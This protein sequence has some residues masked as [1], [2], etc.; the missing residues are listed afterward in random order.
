MRHRATPTSTRLALA[1]L[2]ATGCGGTGDATGPIGGSSTIIVFTTDRHG[3][4]SPDGPGNP[5]IYRMSGNGNDLQRLTDNPAQDWHPA[6]SPDAARIAYIRDQSGARSIRIM[7]SDGTDDRQVTGPGVSAS[8]PVWSRDGQ[9]IAFGCMTEVSLSLDACVIDADGSSLINLTADGT[10]SYEVPGDWAPD[11]SHI[12]VYSN[13]DATDTDI[14]RVNV[15]GSGM[16]KVMDSDE[17][18]RGGPA[19]SPDG[20]RIVFTRRGPIPGVYV[21]NADGSD[22]R[23]ITGSEGAR[24][25]GPSWSPNGGQVLF[26]LRRDNDSDLYVVDD[27][28]SNLG[29]LTETPSIEEFLRQGQAWR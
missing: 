20:S 9:R 18:D 24:Y 10:T 27:D 29:N 3:P 8:S 12:L 14:Y 17:Q 7:N 23:M 26:E 21:M 11:G 16:T 22:I 25:Q 4:A 19:Y 6:L 28:G 1:A 15:D 13:R 2:I 5:E